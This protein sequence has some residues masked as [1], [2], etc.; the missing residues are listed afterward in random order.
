MKQLLRAS[1]PIVSG[2]LLWLAA[3]LQPADRDALRSALV[4]HAA[5]DGGTE[6][7][8]AGGD[9]KLYWAAS[10]KQRDQ[11][12]PGLPETGD[13]LL[14]KGEGRFGDALRFT[15][16]GSPPVFFRGAGNMPYQRE[17][18]NG[19][20]SFWLK[21]DPERELEPGFCD[22]I[23]ITP[24]AWN[25]GAFFVEFEKRPES[26]PFRLG[27]YSDFKVWNPRNRKFAEIPFSEKPLV[28]VDKPPFGGGRWT[29]VVF[30]FEN[31]N[32]GRP[33]A[34]ARLYLDGRRQGELA[35]RQQVFTW[36]TQKVVIALGLS[37]IGLF[38]ELSIFNR[39][40]NDQEVLTLHTQASGV[41]RS[42]AIGPG[43]QR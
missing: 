20:V 40:L 26:I 38:D 18:W 16:K 37:Y 28:T 25:D 5:F 43:R 19:T 8:R 27:V 42:L 30:T 15:K 14:A 11:A 31:F 7:E 17:G 6:A 21:V 4:F 29:H 36:D 2:S 12:K 13:V 41:H 22:P 9:P 39:A 32:T 33:D 10:F 35:G 1:W 24:T 34:T 3:A 23:Q